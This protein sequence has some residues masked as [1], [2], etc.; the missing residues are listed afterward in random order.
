MDLTITQA[1]WQA[2]TH[3]AAAGYY[4]AASALLDAIAS[5]EIPVEV[6]LL[7]AKM[8]AQQRRYDEAIAHW[9]E[10]LSMVPQNQEAQRGMALAR[11]LKDRRGRR[12]YLR[13]NLYYAGLLLTIASLV[14]ALFFATFR[15][16]D[17][18]DTASTKAILDVQERQLQLLREMAEPLKAAVAT[19]K[20]PDIKIDVPGVSVR[21]ETNHLA[22]V[23]KKGLFEAGSARL[24][25]EALSTLSLLG[26]QLEPHSGRIAVCVVG[27][28]D[29]ITVP[30][31]SR[32]RDNVALA[33]SRAVAVV[34]YLRASAHLPAGLFSVRALGEAMAPYPNDTPDRRAGNRTVVIRISRS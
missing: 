5:S 12:F 9:Q 28:T 10:V 20:V 29:S 6:R 24:R 21:S 3:M 30:A 11:E 8:A 23:F 27:H 15:N 18:S 16:A 13:A 22:L 17:Y 1:L 34:E 33:L 32:H 25:P 4:Q 26:R 2:A 19:E 31:G 7:R 14:V